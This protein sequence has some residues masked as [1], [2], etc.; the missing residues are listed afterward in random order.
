MST[1]TSAKAAP[2]PQNVKKQLA[3][4]LKASSKAK[5]AKLSKPKSTKP[6]QIAV[7]APNANLNNNKEGLNLNKIAGKIIKYKNVVN[8]VAPYVQSRIWARLIKKRSLGQA[9]TNNDKKPTR[10]MVYTALVTTLGMRYITSGRGGATEDAPFLPMVAAIPVIPRSLWSTHENSKSIANVNRNMTNLWGALGRRNGTRNRI[11]PPRGGEGE[12]PLSR[13]AIS[14]FYKPAFTQICT[15]NGEWLV[16]GFKVDK[17]R[18]AE[19][20]KEVLGRMGLNSGQAALNIGPGSK[21]TTAAES[22]ILKITIMGYGTAQ[23]TIIFTIGEVK[24]GLGEAAGSKGKE[25]AQLRF[26]MYAI[27]YMFMYIIFSDIDHPWKT[28][29]KIQIESVFLAAGAQNLRNVRFTAQVVPTMVRL[30]NG[31]PVTMSV[32]KV[33]L[34]RFCAIFR[35]DKGRFG[36]AMTA[37][38]KTFL[39]SMQN[40]MAAIGNNASANMAV[41]NTTQLPIIQKLGASLVGAFTP[42]TFKMA[43]LYTPRNAWG[44][45]KTRLNYEVNFLENYHNRLTA[46]GGRN[47]KINEAI[48]GLRGGQVPAAMNTG[49]ASNAVAGNSRARGVVEEATSR[50]VGPTARPNLL[51]PEAQRNEANLLA[52]ERALQHQNNNNGNAVARMMNEGY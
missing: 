52:A 51:S 21:G 32:S 33:D 25:M 41:E 50:L 22:D 15:G 24:V 12:G 37:V 26:S 46:K 14:N 29:T 39:T 6:I 42:N 49:G 30:Q 38:D 7:N 8:N 2:K 47:N 3:I 18:I 31:S 35:L 13:G 44:G 17:K 28:I 11:A 20:A 27:Y 43:K 9:I 48:A 45:N 16:N 34:D 40:Y 10:E 23:A 5:G 19:V 1:K 4:A 36:Q